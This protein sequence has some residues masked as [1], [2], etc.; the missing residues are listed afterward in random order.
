MKKFILR[1]P[2]ISIIVSL[3][4][5]SILL[6][7]SSCNSPEYSQS[8]YNSTFTLNVIDGNHNYSTIGCDSFMLQSKETVVIWQSGKRVEIRAYYISP[9]PSTIT[10]HT[11]R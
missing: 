2:V 1:L 10:I 8:Y 11:G 3:V 4:I 5:T 7:Y 6:L 9:G